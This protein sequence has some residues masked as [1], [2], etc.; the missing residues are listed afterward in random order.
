MYLPFM[1]FKK[2]DFTQM[3][4]KR[5]DDLLFACKKALLVTK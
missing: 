3:E 2:Y 1:P 4:T 5:L